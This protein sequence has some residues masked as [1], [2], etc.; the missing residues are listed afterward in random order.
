MAKNKGKNN[1]NDNRSGITEVT[2]MNNTHAQ[3]KTDN[4]KGNAQNKAGGRQDYK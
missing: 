4:K 3:N 1:A 2:D